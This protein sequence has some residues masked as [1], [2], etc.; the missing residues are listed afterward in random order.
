MLYNVLEP[1]GWPK[2]YPDDPMSRSPSP[3]NVDIYDGYRSPMR[4]EDGDV[5]AIRPLGV[6]KHFNPRGP[7]GVLH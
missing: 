3:D 1:D 6:P 2:F 7:R 4:S 5:D